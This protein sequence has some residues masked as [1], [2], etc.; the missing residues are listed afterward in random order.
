MST[1]SNAVRSICDMLSIRPEGA[2]FSCI[3][4]TLNIDKDEANKAIQLLVG[5]GA[6]RSESD[7]YIAFPWWNYDRIDISLNIPPVSQETFNEYVKTLDDFILYVR[8]E[9][10]DVVRPHTHET[11]IQVILTAAAG[12][13]L[14][15]F[16]KPF[17]GELGKRFAAFI[18]DTLLKFRNKGIQKIQFKA[19]RMVD[20]GNYLSATI[21]ASSKDEFSQLLSIVDDNFQKGLS[22]RNV[23]EELSISGKNWE[24]TL[25]KLKEPE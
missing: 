6:I 16:F 1:D 3:T 20:D 12:F 22:A 9:D 25:K 19:I 14:A 24:V 7:T 23:G 15:E 5:V 21:N 4:E 13:A 10:V 18:G 17:F 8:E 2:T 11:T